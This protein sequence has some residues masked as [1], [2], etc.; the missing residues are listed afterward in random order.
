MAGRNIAENI[1]APESRKRFTAVN[2]AA[3][4]SV[5]TARHVAVLDYR[6]GWNDESGGRRLI[7]LYRNFIYLRERAGLVIGVEL[8][9]ALTQRI[10]I[11]GSFVNNDYRFPSA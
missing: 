4:H 1:L 10:P 11:I 9:V 3:R 5:A 6:I 7:D 8:L 2:E